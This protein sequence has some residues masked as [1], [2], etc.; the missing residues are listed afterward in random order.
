MLNQ[1][2]G[3]LRICKP[4]M[5]EEEFGML[6]KAMNL[7]LDACQ[8]KPVKLGDHTI[9]HALGVASITAGEIG[10]GVTSIISSLLFDF[11]LD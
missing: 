2:R 4:D 1:Y 9:F 8:D 3:L 10:L 6:K 7:A 11:Y 5:S